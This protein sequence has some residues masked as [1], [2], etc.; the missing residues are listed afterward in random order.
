[1]RRRNRNGIV[2]TIGR[3]LAIAF[4]IG[5]AGCAARQPV[6]QRGDVAISDDVRAR[7]AADAQVGASHVQVDTTNGVVHLTGNVPTDRDRSS[8]EQI[9]RDTAGVRSVDNNIIFGR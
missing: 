3:S 8:A 4:V 6:V 9:A 5:A 7:L 2:F 1:M